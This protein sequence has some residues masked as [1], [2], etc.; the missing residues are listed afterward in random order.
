MIVLQADIDLVK[1]GK[2]RRRQMWLPVTWGD[3][4][5]RLPCP[6]ELG[7]LVSLQTRPFEKGT[8]ITVA[9]IYL[10]HLGAMTT[11]DARLQGYG[12]VQSARA[13][14]TE[15]HGALDDEHPS[16]VVRFL[17]GDH[18]EIFN[19]HAE[20]YLVAKMGGG[21][22]YTTDPSKGAKGEG[23]VPTAE[24]SAFAH[25]AIVAREDSKQKQWRELRKAL[26]REIKAMRQHELDRDEEKELKRLERRLQQLDAQAA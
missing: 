26:A 5:E 17:L 21:R 1:R 9:E 13:S 4:E 16:W 6:V 2:P 11:A 23:A 8:R 25:R 15:I 18:A 12:G 10:S 20:K 19:E 3:L 24:L 22:S 7:Q 14:I